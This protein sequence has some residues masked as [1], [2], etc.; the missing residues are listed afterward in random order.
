[1]IKTY[2]LLYPLGHEYEDPDDFNWSPYM[3]SLVR[4]NINDECLTDY[5]SIQQLF[6]VLSPNCN[7]GYDVIKTRVNFFL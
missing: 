1:M 5:E 7:L 4:V 6:D 3:I 2:F